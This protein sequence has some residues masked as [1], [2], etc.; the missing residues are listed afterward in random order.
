MPSVAKHSYLKGVSGKA[1]AKAHVNYIQYRSGEEREKEPM[2]FFSRECDDV[3]GHEIK[4]DIDEQSL[5]GVAVHKIILSPGVDNV[6]LQQYTREMMDE[7]GHSKGLDL[8][9]YA[10]AHRNTE[11]DHVHVVVMG[12]DENGHQ[13]R[14]D[15]NDHRTMRDIG[16]RYIEREHYLERYLD[17]DIALLLKHGERDRELDYNKERGDRQ[18]NLLIYGETKDRKRGEDPERDRRE[19]EELDKDLHKNL[20]RERGLE[21]PGG[22]I[23]RRIEFQGRFSD[24]IY[25]SANQQFKQQWREAAEYNPGLAEAA[26]RELAWISKFEQESMVQNHLRHDGLD[27][28]LGHEMGRGRDQP[29]LTDHGHHSQPEQGTSRAWET[30]ESNRQTKSQEENR[31]S[32]RE[33]DS[34]RGER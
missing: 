10:V 29:E 20:N 15:R 11:H 9:W 12:R 31:G 5:R 28:L 21:I 1:R 25:Y 16:D 23:Q 6:D 3:Q 27:R 18:F 19:F 7:L 4:H 2:Q 14:F 17:R 33:D 26:T 30:F 32:D 13:V 22:R 8:D 24:A 34:R